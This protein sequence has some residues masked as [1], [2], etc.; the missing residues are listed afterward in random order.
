MR[1]QV[2]GGEDIEARMRAYLRNL[3]GSLRGAADLEVR[4]LPVSGSSRRYA[5]V[6]FPDRE[7]SRIACLSDDVSENRV[8]ISLTRALGDAGVAVPSIVAVSSDGRF[9]IQSDLGSDSLFDRIS[10]DEVG[11]DGNRHPAARVEARVAEAMRDLAFIHTLPSGIWE[12][13][14]GFSPFGPEL[15][16]GDCRYFLERFLIPSGVEFDPGAL[17]RDFDRLGC[18]LCD[19]QP[20]FTGF[21]YRD[22]Q[23]RNVMVCGNGVADRNY[24]IDYQSGRR[25]P[26]LY[27]VASF[28]WQ[29]KARFA[30]DFRRRM[31]GEYAAALSSHRRDC[32]AE[33]VLEPL[34]DFVLFRTLQVLGAYGFRGLVEGKRH[35]IESIPPAVGNLRQLVADGV[36]DTY[37][38]LARLSE[39]LSERYK[40]ID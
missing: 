24:Y 8:F 20:G 19:G 35:F 17:R 11:A 2:P 15:A 31:A 34:G 6:V 25:G 29:A 12:R 39:R 16:E 10:R 14:V 21:M 32:D 1:N 30:P 38:E 3:E 4:L 13:H 18:K 37:P 28:L 5:R 7:Q 40:D 23:S 9:Y 27:D 22:F 33:R 36:C 26:G